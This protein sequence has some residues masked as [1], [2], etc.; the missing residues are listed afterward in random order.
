MSQNSNSTYEKSTTDGSEEEFSNQKSKR[1][2]IFHNFD[3]KV[4]K[5]VMEQV[6]ELREYLDFSEKRPPC[7]REE[8]ISALITNNGDLVNAIMELSI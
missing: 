3:E 1:S 6:S 4:I 2:K 8:A 5:L 7:N